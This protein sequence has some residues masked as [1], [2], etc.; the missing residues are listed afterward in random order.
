MLSPSLPVAVA[1]NHFATDADAE[2]A[3]LADLC[4]ERLGVEGSTGT[5]TGNHLHLEMKN[6]D[7]V[8]F[9]PVLW[10]QTRQMRLEGSS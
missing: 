5:S 10:L 2:H 3:R 1:V 8:S 7:S 4:R 6:S 9:D